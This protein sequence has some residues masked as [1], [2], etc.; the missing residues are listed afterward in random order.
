MKF[1]ASAI[2]TFHK[3]GILGHQ[4]LLAVERCRM[5]AESL[6]LTVEL[7]ITLDCPDAE[8]VRV[9][10]DHPAIRESDQVYQVTFKDLSTCRNFAIS[11]SLGDY[12]GTFDGDDYWS[13]NWISHSVQMIQSEGEHNIIHPEMIFAFGEV[14]SYWWQIDQ[15]GAYYRPATQLTTNYWN[16]CAFAAKSVFEKCPYQV[17]RVGEAGFGYEDWHWNCETIAEGYI[18]RTAKGTIR[19]ERRKENGSLNIAHRH[20]GA[21][22]KP[23]KFF[24]KIC[25]A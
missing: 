22:I 16:A 25:N 17:S 21:I 10:H 8:T 2:V 12:I 1:D 24:D 9:V 19:Y 11:K 20:A 3:E 6:G 7:V 18:H 15:L 5:H 13:K 14:N 23:S 4:T